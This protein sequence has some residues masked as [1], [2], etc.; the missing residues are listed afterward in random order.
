MAWLEARVGLGTCVN[1][2]WLMGVIAPTTVPATVWPKATGAA[3]STCCPVPLFPE[4]ATEEAAVLLLL[5]GVAWALCVA[6]PVA[7]KYKAVR[8]GTLQ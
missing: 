2:G 5:T 4:E 8:Y 7:V 1:L 3:P 6:V